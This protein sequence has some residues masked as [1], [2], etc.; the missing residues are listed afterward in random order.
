MSVRLVGID[1]DG[2]L[3]GSSGVVDERNWRA[4]QRLR[5]S[6]VHLALCSGRPAFGIAREYAERLDPDGWHVF[7]NGASVVRL[8]DGRSRSTPLADGLVAGFAQEARETGR[9]LELYSDGDYVVER[10]EA[11]SCQHAEL[12]GLPYRPRPF[13]SLEPP[14]VRAQW[15]LPR[16]LADEWRGRRDERLEVALSS[17]PLM[18]DTTFVGITPRGV[19]KGS[20]LQSIAEALG[21][22]MAEVMYVGDAGNDLSAMQRVGYPVAMGNADED[23]RRAAR[24]VVGSVEHAGLAEALEWAAAT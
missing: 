21:I 9:I 16:E 15:L 11:W 3:V 18:P 24:H 8:A 1:V 20:A 23:V 5:E 10:D 17:S 2:T 4:A 7:Q 13:E 19:C 6:G 22:A 14:V 12:L